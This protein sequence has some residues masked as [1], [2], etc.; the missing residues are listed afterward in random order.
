MSQV[1]EKCDLKCSAVF[2]LDL[3]VEVI[4]PGFFT[5]GSAGG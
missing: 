1:T 2:K 4:R 5:D 3:P